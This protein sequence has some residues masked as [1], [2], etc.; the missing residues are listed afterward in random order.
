MKRT[1]T[2]A[3][4]VWREMLRKKD[5]YV[6]LILLTVLL[7]SLLSVDVFGLQNVAGYAKDLGLLFAW[8]FAWI[9]AVTVA[10]RELPEEEK[11]GTIY[12]LLAKPIDRLELIL[13]KWLGSW[14]VVCAATFC[15]YAM[16]AAVAIA[17]GSPFRR[18]AL[19]EGY[20]LH[21]AALAIVSATALALSTRMNFDAA[22]T[23]S[24]AI[25]GSAFL[26]VPR[27]PH[28]VTLEQG[29]RSIALQVL[30]YVLPHFELF[31]MRQRLVHAEDPIGITVLGQILIYGALMTAALVTLAWLGYRRKRFMRGDAT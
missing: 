29:M 17:R 14:S 15:F 31:D 23:F 20:V 3:S 24:L 16:L 28:L 27:I 30:Y 21:A 2:I 13:G 4:V 10:A 11:R 5:V 9:L 26:V 12:P 7:F 22:A 8:L 6:L 25:T 19:I 1:L 18:D